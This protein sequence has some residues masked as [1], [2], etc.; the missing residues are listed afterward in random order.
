MVRTVLILGGLA[1]ALATGR[2]VMAQKTP[3]SE[4]R[5][6]FAAHCKGCHGP[7]GKG[8]S[9]LGQ[10]LGVPDLTSAKFQEVRRDEQM[11]QS[12]KAG[13]K[14]GT[15]VRMISYEGKLTDKEIQSL[16]AYI[17]GLKSK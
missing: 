2:A 8:D 6:L 10:K 11:F 4:P 12:I 13:I 15:T 9:K 17:R 3:G 5:E 1:G 7:A 14:Q 16:V